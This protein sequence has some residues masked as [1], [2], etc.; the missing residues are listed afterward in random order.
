MKWKMSDLSVFLERLR[1]GKSGNAQKEN[2]QEK[3]LLNQLQDAHER[4]KRLEA[5]AEENQQLRHERVQLSE[6]IQRL[7]KRLV[8]CAKEKE[9]YK[10]AL[11]EVENWRK[12]WREQLASPP[13]TYG[14]FVRPHPGGKLEEVDVL[15]EGQFR[16]LPLAIPNTKATDLKSGWEVGVNGKSQVVEVTK[17]YWN[18]GSAV[19]FRSYINPE[20]AEVES[21]HNEIQQCYISPDLKETRLK[22]GDR[23][24]NCGGVLIRVLPKT[25]ESEH[26]LDL[27]NVSDIT[28]DQVGGLSKSVKKIQRILLPF[29]EREVY[30]KVFKGKDMPKGLILHGPEGCGKTLCAKAIGADLGRSLGLPCFF[31]NIGGA[32]LTHK[33]V[34]ETARKIREVFA[35]AKEKAAEGALVVVFID[36]IDSLFRS[37]DTSEHEPWMATDIGQFNQILD[38]V[39]PL[40]N[41]LVLAAT[42]RKDLV[43][44]A[45]LRPGRL[46]VDVFIP[47]PK[48]MRDVKEILRIYLAADLPFS[49]KYLENHIYKYIDSFGSGE[50]EE[51]VLSGDLEKIREHFIDLIAKRLAYTGREVKIRFSD[52]TELTVNNIFRVE[53]VKGNEDVMLKN[54]LSGAIIKSIVDGAKMIALERYHRS[55][56]AGEKDPVAD[57]KKKDFFMA[58]DE[59]VERLK[60]NFKEAVNKP[61][62]GFAG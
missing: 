60:N 35:R 30:V 47:R 29:K 23:L 33:Y 15:I 7:L 5:K 17:L 41:I 43:D 24:L 38:G 42:N 56:V 27:Q 4:I 62:T 44:K 39:D 37:R 21:S 20:L 19:T 14:I 10:K 32:E 57:I 26:F 3:E 61:I 22:D 52:G 2:H 12:K 1:K 59:E 8:E 58:I 55:K 48:T 18:W 50:E 16:K 31:M 49:R 54:Y 11:E 6:E 13:L 9:R 40:G 53:T 46:G 28:W 34:G 36:E 25:E 45:I 51:V